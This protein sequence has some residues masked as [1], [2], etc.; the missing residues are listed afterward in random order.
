MRKGEGT[1]AFGVA[2][3]QGDSV[4]LDE[5]L[6]F[7]RH[8]LFGRGELEV[9]EAILARGPDFDGHVDGELSV[10]VLQTVRMCTDTF[11]SGD[12]SQEKRLS[13]PVFP[14]HKRLRTA[15]SHDVWAALLLMV[16]YQSAGQ[17]MMMK[18]LRTTAR[19]PRGIRAFVVASGMNST[20][21]ISRSFDGSDV[22]RAWAT[23]F[24]HSKPETLFFTRIEFTEAISCSLL[25]QSGR[26]DEM[27]QER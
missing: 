16:A 3:I 24:Q 14:R 12:L 7:L 20:C 15:S 26:S 25:N 13:A 10:S 6:A 4:D 9:I 2:V 19:Y 18:L 8:R 5:H 22:Y 17:A 11:G 21:V 27:E 1:R 23:I